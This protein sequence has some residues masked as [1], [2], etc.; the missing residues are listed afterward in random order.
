MRKG[1][2][3]STKSA[4]EVMGWTM[5]ATRELVQPQDCFVPV[6]S[7]CSARVG[8]LWQVKLEYADRFRNFG[9]IA[10]GKAS[11]ELAKAYTF[12]RSTLVAAIAAEAAIGPFSLR[13]EDL[14]LDAS[15][16]AFLSPLVQNSPK[17]TG[18][19]PIFETLKGNWKGQDSVLPLIFA[20]LKG[21]LDCAKQQ[22]LN[23][24]L[25]YLSEA[26][27][28]MASNVLST[29]NALIKTSDIVAWQSL[30]PLSRLFLEVFPVAFTL[31]CSP[32]C[33]GLGRLR[34]T[35]CAQHYF[36]SEACK[37]ACTGQDKGDCGLCSGKKRCFCGNEPKSEWRMTYL[38]C[39]LYTETA[40]YCSEACFL[41]RNPPKPV[42]DADAEVWTC[43][44]CETIGEVHE[45]RYSLDCGEH[46]FC[47]SK[48]YH[49]YL[50]ETVPPGFEIWPQCLICSKSLTVLAKESRRT[51]E[52]RATIARID[53]ERATYLRIKNHTAFSSLFNMIN[54]VEA[55]LIQDVRPGMKFNEEIC[56]EDMLNHVHFLECLA[57]QEPTVVHKR[58]RTEMLTWGDVPFLVKCELKLHA[59][60]S[61]ACLDALRQGRGNCP[62]C[63]EFAIDFE[64]ASVSRS[65]KHPTLEALRRTAG[66][67]C[68]CRRYDTEYISLPKCAHEVC[69]Q[70]LLTHLVDKQEEDY[71]CKLCQQETSRE[72]L[73]TQV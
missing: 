73:L 60:C 6:R 53:Q 17:T 68:R 23:T 52:M 31:C 56:M 8:D 36:C 15:G 48:C 7:V 27:Q 25:T 21:L 40:K 42:S 61:M 46:V 64:L 28:D 63:G 30:A 12:L 13:P 35:A 11:L 49:E 19:V 5:R 65:L 9:D 29:A 58:Q 32:M 72:Y 66:S 16:R 33:S 50:R 3:R 20:L 43:L 47:S 45:P 4:E 41:I 26:V 70:C 18:I 69:A 51:E 1:E 59:V 34:V 14:Y 2:E 54:E 62:V 24:T 44:N 39:A 71:T 55:M 57:C 22:D 37:L 38:G 67:Y 10:A